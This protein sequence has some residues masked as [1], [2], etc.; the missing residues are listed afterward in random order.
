MNLLFDK[1]KS[2]ALRPA[3]WASAPCSQ[4]GPA[5]AGAIDERPPS[6]AAARGAPLCQ[7][8]SVTTIAFDEN[9][10]SAIVAPAASRVRMLPEGGV[11]EDRNP[12]P[13]FRSS[14]TRHQDRVRGFL[15]NHPGPP[16]QPAGWLSF[17]RPPQAPEGAG[18]VPDVLDGPT[19]QGFVAGAKSRAQARIRLSGRMLG[20]AWSRLLHRDPIMPALSDL[21]L[22]GSLLRAQPSAGPLRNQRITYSPSRAFCKDPVGSRG[23]LGAG[24]DAIVSQPADAPVRPLKGPPTFFPSFTHRHRALF[25]GTKPSRPRARES[26]RQLPLR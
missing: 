2:R 9:P 10:L 5:G 15:I 23:E 8:A 14:E 4:W 22:A 3:V 19:G 16:E 7:E 11:S 6:S 24:E 26:L 17:C 18:L 13:R 1:S 21:A 25:G 20:R 12:V